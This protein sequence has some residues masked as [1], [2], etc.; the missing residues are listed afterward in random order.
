MGG[1]REF[2]GLVGW[3]VRSGDVLVKKGVWGG[4]MGC[5]TVGR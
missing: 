2:S 5:G 1:L 3:G 4:G